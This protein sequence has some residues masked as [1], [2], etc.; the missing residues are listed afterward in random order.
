M[1]LQEKTIV[2]LQEVLQVFTFNLWF[3][4]NIFLNESLQGQRISFTFSLEAERKNIFHSTKIKRLSH[5]VFADDPD[6]VNEDD[7]GRQIV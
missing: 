6:Y 1:F 4:S 7:W 5:L 2:S 3:D